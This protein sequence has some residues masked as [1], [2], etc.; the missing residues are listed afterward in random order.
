VTYRGIRIYCTSAG[1]T[2]LTKCGHINRRPTNDL[3]VAISRHIAG[4]AIH[5]L[6]SRTT[7]L[8]RHSSS[9]ELGISFLSELWSAFRLIPKCRPSFPLSCVLQSADQSYSNRSAQRSSL[10]PSHSLFDCTR[11]GG[12]HHASSGDRGNAVH[13]NL[14][15]DAARWAVGVASFQYFMS[16][17]RRDS[18]RPLR[19]PTVNNSAIISPKYTKPS[20]NFCQ[21]DRARLVALG[22]TRPLSGTTG[23]EPAF[24]AGE[25]SLVTGCKHENDYDRCC[26][27]RCAC[28]R[29]GF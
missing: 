11:A 5:H 28:N 23:F 8:A 21:I 18:Q 15:H 1:L 6:G 17:I 13:S 9:L 19:L 20:A 26:R 22:G 27:G 12:N 7:R 3:K 16:I 24:G 10:Q 14:S 2:L 25:L 4:T 29:R